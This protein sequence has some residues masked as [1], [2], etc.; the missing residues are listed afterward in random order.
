MGKA[1][2]TPLVVNDQEDN[3]HKKLFWR[4]SHEPIFVGQLTI[5]NN[6]VYV[7]GPRVYIQ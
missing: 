6:G 3:C 4:V 1:I 7:L 5:S 2:K